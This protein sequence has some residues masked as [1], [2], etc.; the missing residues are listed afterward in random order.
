MITFFN[1]LFNSYFQLQDIFGSAL[2]QHFYHFVMLVFRFDQEIPRDFL[3]L[4]N[5]ISI[6]IK[7][8]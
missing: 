7:I 4:Q 8:W 6:S 1:P 2:L 5:K 3:Q